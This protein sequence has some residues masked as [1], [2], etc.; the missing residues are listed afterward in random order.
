MVDSFHDCFNRF[1]LGSGL[2]GLYHHNRYWYLGIKQNSRLGMGYYQFRLVGRYRARRYPYFSRIIIIPSEMENGNQPFCRSYDHF[3]CSSGRFVPYYSHGTSLACILGS[4]NAQPVRIALGYFNSPLLWDVFAISTYLSVSLVFWWTGLLP[5]FAMLRDRAVTPFTK[6]IYSTLSFGWSGRA[7]DWQRFEEVSL[8]LAGLATPL[9]LSVHT[10]VSMD[11]ATSVIPGWHTT[12][13]PPYFVAGAVFS[14]FAMVNTLLIIMR[15]V[16]SLEDYI[17]IQHIELMNIII[18]I[19]GSIVGVA[20]ITE[21]VIA[22]YSGVEY[23]QYAF[24]N[25]AT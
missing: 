22:W 8:V 6:R 5:D 18:M 1:P 14:G 9:V 17:T 4:A 7:K 2:Y 11:F 21:L 23:E 12:I 13:F 24:L 19:T 20:Y 10:I 3:L 15:K 25:R 16:V